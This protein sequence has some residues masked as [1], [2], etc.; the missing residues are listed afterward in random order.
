MRNVPSLAL[1][2]IA[3]IPTQSIAADFVITTVDACPY[4]CANPDRKGYIIDVLEGIFERKNIEVEFIQN[5]W[6]RGIKLAEIGKVD[7][8]L[9]PTKAEAPSLYYPD[10]SIGLQRECFITKKG[11]QWKYDKN[12][13]LK[14]QKVIVPSGWGHESALIE[15]IGQATY[16]KTF[17]HFDYNKDYYSR[18][19]DMLNRDRVDAI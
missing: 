10:Q 9:A 3:F 7:M 17:I 5:P 12:E 19:I 8:V 15:D 1:I 6:K 18:A 4:M 2:A 14:E 13:N 16:D 11:S